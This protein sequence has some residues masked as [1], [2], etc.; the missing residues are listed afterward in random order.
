MPFELTRVVWTD[1]CFP[2]GCQFALDRSALFYFQSAAMVVSTTGSRKLTIAGWVLSGIVAAFLALVSAAGK[3]IQP[4]PQG[5][6][7]AANHLGLPIEK[8]PAIGVLEIACVIL[9]LIPRTAFLGAILLAGYLGG[10]AAIHV[11]VGDPW[12]FPILFG[13][14]AWVGY[15][16]RRPD[17]IRAAFAPRPGQ[18]SS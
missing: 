9:F 1:N 2:P 4:P 18:Q 3:F 10:A 5:T 17:V 15:G 11:R 14:L 16:L 7:D 13:V 8:F 12:V 6:L